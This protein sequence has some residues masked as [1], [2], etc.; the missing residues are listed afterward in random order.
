MDNLYRSQRRAVACVII[1]LAAFRGCLAIENCCR[2]TA[3]A[4]TQHAEGA[5]TSR[6][7][8]ALV[9]H[10][11]R[12]P[13][14]PVVTAAVVRG[15][16]YGR[17]GAAP[18]PAPPAAV[19]MRVTAYCACFHCTGKHPGDPAYGITASGRPVTANGGRFCAAPRSIP[20]GTMID[21][22]GY[23]VVPVLDR[24]GAITGDRLDVYC[25][26]H[27]E[28][29]NWGVKWLDVKIMSRTEN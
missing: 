13:G 4:A 2:R 22:P 16:E 18:T 25:P 20:F 3:R 15:A 1:S 7:T 23:G 9:R 21:I 12:R 26:T 24:G 11:D 8:E 19:R 27:Q 17:L 28:A 6:V 10:G 14:L 29:L 5:A